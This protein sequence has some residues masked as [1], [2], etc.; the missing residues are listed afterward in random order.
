[1]RF[2]R[3]RMMAGANYF[4]SI[5]QLLQAEKA[6]RL[7]AFLK[8]TKVPINELSKIFEETNDYECENDFNYASEICDYLFSTNIEFTNEDPAL[9]SVLFYIG[10]FIARSISKQKSCPGCRRLLVDDSSFNTNQIQC[11]KEDEAEKKVC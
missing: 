11:T 10:G 6:L 2:G 3:Y 7:R 9:N 8:Y 5:R 1:K 4:I